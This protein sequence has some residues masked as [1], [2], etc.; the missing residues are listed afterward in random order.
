MLLA[1][2]W[3]GCFDD[4]EAEVDTD[5]QA[6]SDGGPSQTTNASEGDSGGSDAAAS[7]GVADS[8]GGDGVC[9]NG[10]AEGTEQCDD[11]NDDETDACT[12]LCAPP[13][14]EDGLRSGD[15]SD[16]DCG[17]SCEPCADGSACDQPRDCAS[18]QCYVGVCQLACAPW[19][20]QFGTAESD[21][22]VQLDLAAD[23]SVYVA[24]STGAGLGGNKHAGGLDL[25]YARVD[26]RGVLDFSRQLGGAGDDLLRAMA[27]SPDGN[28]ALVGSATDAFDGH[29]ALGDLDAVV[30]VYD[31]NTTKLW[32]RQVGTS[33]EDRFEAVGFASDGKL[34]VAGLT[35]GSYGGDPNLGSGDTLVIKLDTDGSE[36]WSRQYGSTAIDVAYGLGVDSTDAVILGGYAGAVFDDNRV[37]GEQDG[38]LSKLDSDGAKQWSVQLGTPARDEVTDIVIGD[39]DAIYIGGYTYGALGARSNAGG[40]DAY[41]GKLDADGN[42]LWLAQL[43]SSGDE[44]VRH[45]ALDAEGRLWVA[46]PTDGDLDTGVSAG[47]HDFY[48]ARFSADGEFE[49]LWQAGT[50]AEDVAGGVAIGQHG[51]VYVSGHTGGA[52]VRRS[53]GGADAVV[54][55]IC[56]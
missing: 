34:Y 47:G 7:D 51:E 50:D 2:T 24:G 31:D 8:S 12:S 40:S 30:A 48:V 11:G 16:V 5:A 56:P 14:C 49:G 22:D 52:L 46:G 1:C 13:S 54:Q 6:S 3:T 20:L 28:V 32:S 4:P 39:D 37:V 41:V 25:F 9:G 33:A 44:F 36:I 27:V 26:A 35:R 43:G 10:I 17:G 42:E 23:G 21:V 38:V 15:E 29:A 55:R 18:E 45:L 19:G 53:F